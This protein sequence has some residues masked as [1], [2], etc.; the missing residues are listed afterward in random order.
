MLTIKPSSIVLDFDRSR[1]S[2]AR[3]NPRAT[4][5]AGAAMAAVKLAAEIALY[6]G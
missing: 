5:S 1:S 4:P 6:M 3:K 2:Y